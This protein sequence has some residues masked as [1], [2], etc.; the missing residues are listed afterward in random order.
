MEEDSDDDSS[1]DD[2]PWN[3]PRGQ[4]KQLRPPTAAA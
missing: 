2:E 3:A 4:G 1:S